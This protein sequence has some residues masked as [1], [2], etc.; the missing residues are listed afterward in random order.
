[1]I[2]GWFAKGVYCA[3][4]TLN[5]RPIDSKEMESPRGYIHCE[6]LADGPEVY[7]QI[8]RSEVDKVIFIVEQDSL[9]TDAFQEVG[10]F[11][12]GGDAPFTLKEPPGFN[13]GPGGN[14]E[15][16]IGFL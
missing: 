3:L 14:I 6:T 7:F 12:I 13:E 5:H 2:G 10:E 9:R 11:R 8:R 16:A 15:C 4:S 1:M